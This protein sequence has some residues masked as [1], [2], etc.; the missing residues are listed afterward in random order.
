[1]RTLFFGLLPVW[2]LA[3]ADAGFDGRWNI[4]VPKEP[5]NRSWWLEVKG[6]KGRFVGAPGG[7]MYDIPHISTNGEDL[8]FS[9]EG[10]QRR[11]PDEE[12]RAHIANG[13][14]RGT[15]K[16][17]KD[18]FDWIGLRA[19]DIPDRD[20]GTWKPTEAVPLFNGFDITG[21]RA[22]IPD[23]PLGW[24]VK[25]GALTNVAGANNLISTRRFW[26]YDLHA[27]FKVG[28]HSNSG[29]GLRGRYEIQ[30]LED[31]GKPPDT[32]GNGA[33][34]SRIAPSVNA[35]KPAGEWQTLDIRIVGRDLT[36]VLNGKKVID[37]GLVEGLT[38]IANNPDEGAPGPFILQGDHGPVEFRKLTV[39]P[40]RK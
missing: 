16:A 40:L 37:K 32:H 14:L 36:V 13:R 23:K 4:H 26:N 38:A 22:M 15:L 34:Y 29:I 33:L 9:F 31:F 19:P 28:E 10:P 24:S 35:S 11:A 17:G 2:A 3:A 25:D 18:Y 12:Y 5:R 20:D 27:E 8:V 1:M 21:W 30:I 7:G 39:T 6:G